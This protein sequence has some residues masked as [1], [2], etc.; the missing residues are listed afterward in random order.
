M[1]LALMGAAPSKARLLGACRNEGTVLAEGSDNCHIIGGGP[2]LRTWVFNDVQASVRPH[3]WVTL[4]D[5]DAT[6]G[7]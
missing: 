3:V 4:L 2:A 7:Q 1:K 6:P 5:R